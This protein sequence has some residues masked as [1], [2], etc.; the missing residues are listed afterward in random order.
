MDAL[1]G[2]HS[3]T[4]IDV[5]VEHSEDMN[6]DIAFSEILNEKKYLKCHENSVHEE[7]NSF[8]YQYDFGDKKVIKKELP[9]DIQD[10]TMHF[11]QS[12]NEESHLKYVK[13][14]QNSTMFD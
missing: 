8:V 10:E 3:D 12:L 2:N 7:E 14:D 4:N 1:H 13:N 11:P 9:K 5:K 6:K